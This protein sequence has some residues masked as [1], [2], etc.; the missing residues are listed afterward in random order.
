MEKVC[1]T[2]AAGRPGPYGDTSVLCSIVNREFWHDAHCD[3]WQEK[4]KE[5]NFTE[6]PYR[7]V[8]PKPILKP[9][10]P[11]LNI[12]EKN[13][14]SIS[15]PSVTE[16]LDKINISKK[17]PDKGYVYILTNRAIP[18]FVKIGKTTKIPEY[19]AS[20][21]STST[22]VP[23]PYQVFY[24][25]YVKNCSDM[26]KEIHEKLH[27]CR[28]NLGREFFKIPPDEAKTVLQELSFKYKIE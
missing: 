6:N 1:K 15:S 2:C 3:Y 24:S 17:F 21:I 22:G 10:K 27:H 18:E 9:L 23:V 25:V 26:E 12:I 16:I 5:N 28:E 13:K 7:V 14:P 8:G 11:I 19:R 20:E 4:T